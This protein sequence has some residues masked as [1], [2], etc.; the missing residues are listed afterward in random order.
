MVEV[1]EKSLTLFLAMH[2]TA[3]ESLSRFSTHYAHNLEKLRASAEE[4]NEVF[5]D[6]DIK[7]FTKP[8][9]DKKGAL[10]QHLRYGSQSTTDGFKTQLGK[11]YPIV[12][13]IFYNCILRLEDGDKAMIN[14]NSLLYFIVTKSDMSQINNHGLVF[15]AIQSNASYFTEYVSYCHDLEKERK[16]VFEQLSRNDSN[17]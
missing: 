15:D 1:V 6:E 12:D 7:Q 14:G 3:E 17:K 4:Y 13:K 2:E 9:D 16:A 10:Y 11:L 5:A 8:F